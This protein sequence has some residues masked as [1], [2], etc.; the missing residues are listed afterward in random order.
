MLKTETQEK[1][2]KPKFPRLAKVAFTDGSWV[3]LQLD[4]HRG[5]I[6]TGGPEHNGQIIDVLKYAVSDY[7]GR[8]TLCNDNEFFEEKS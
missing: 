8:I 2:P 7:V 1:Q 6:L 5:V 4:E 3:V